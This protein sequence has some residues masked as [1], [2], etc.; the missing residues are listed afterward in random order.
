MGGRVVT[1]DI[2]PHDFLISI[3]YH[4]LITIF[5][6]TVFRSIEQVA[7]SCSFLFIISKSR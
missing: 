6:P 2:S 1:Y 7:F 5:P 3:T 4:L